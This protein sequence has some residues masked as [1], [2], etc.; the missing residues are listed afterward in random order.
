MNSLNTECGYRF[1]H[2]FFREVPPSSLKFQSFHFTG[3][4]GFYHEYGVYTIYEGPQVIVYVLYIPFP[5]L[6]LE[7]KT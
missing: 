7:R 2:L 5:L 6:N 1:I 4:I 3:I